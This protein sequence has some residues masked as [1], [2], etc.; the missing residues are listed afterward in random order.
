MNN[1][2]YYDILGIDKNADLNIIK[3]AYREKA[4]KYHPDKNRSNIVDSER[5]FKLIIN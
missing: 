3:K 1:K 4:L 2:N 5:K